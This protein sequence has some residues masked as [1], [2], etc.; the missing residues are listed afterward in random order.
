MLQSL[1]ELR[2][3]A[4]QNVQNC[5]G[6]ELVA[7]PDLIAYSLKSHKE[8]FPSFERESVLNNTHMRIRNKESQIAYL[9]YQW[10]LHIRACGDF[11][12]A[13]FSYDVIL[14]KL[15]TTL[16]HDKK[17]WELLPNLDWDND[18]KR[19]PAELIN[20]FIDKELQDINDANN[21]RLFLSGKS[22]L[23]TKQVKDKADSLEGK[24]FNRTTIDYIASAATS[25]MLLINDSSGKVD[26]FIEMYFKDNELRHII[27]N[28]ATIPI[29]LT[30]SI[31]IQKTKESNIIGKNV[32]YYGAPGTGKSHTIDNEVTGS[33]FRRIVFHS[34]TQNSDFIGSLKPVMENDNSDGKEILSYRFV[35]GPF[36]ESYIEAKK[37]PQHHHY[38]VIEEINRAQAATVFGEIFQ[39]LDRNE[40]GQGR[41]QI[42]VT[43]LTLAKYIRQK[44]AISESESVKLRMPENLSLLATMN[45]SDQA[46]MPMDTAFKRRWS[47]RYIPIEMS[48]APSGTLPIPL[49]PGTKTQVKWET[50]ALVINE[51]LAQQSITEDRHLGPFFITKSEMNEDTLTGK[52]LMYLWDDVLRHT[53]KNVMFAQHTTTFGDLLRKYNQNIPIFSQLVNERLQDSLTSKA[54]TDSDIIEQT[55]SETEH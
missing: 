51:T 23:N 38:L 2:E 35:P 24:K 14:K 45:S 33:S 55:L 25:L 47:F 52:V 9:P 31:P 41:Y 30:T 18:P 19:Y 44:L 6:Q 49:T 1:E 48:F 32:I 11:I 17:L 4:K 12:D 16:S 28:A 37:N 40:D 22:W 34:D 36:I 53:P 42:E 5:I 10:F 15:K 13:L 26:Q 50:L 20:N 8:I 3:K 43:D 46:V 21:F 7:T 39:L 54:I 29:I 27:D